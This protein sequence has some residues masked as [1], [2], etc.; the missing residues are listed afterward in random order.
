MQIVYHRNHLCTNHLDVYGYVQVTK[1]LTYI[2]VDYE[3]CKT[4][5]ETSLDY[6]GDHFRFQN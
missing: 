4:F 1:Y 3:F 5:W 2:I 6:F